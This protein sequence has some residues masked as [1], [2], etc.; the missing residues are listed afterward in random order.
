M[1]RRRGLAAL[2]LAA[3]Y[4]AGAPAHAGGNLEA[5]VANGT[6]IA[7]AAWDTRALPVTWRIN[8]QGVINNCNN[9]NPTCSGGVSPLT[10]QRAIDAMI[11]DFNAWQDVPSSRIA[12][13]FAG[14][15]A[16]TTVGLDELRL[17]TWT[18]NRTNVCPTG[19]VATT[20]SSR[21]SAD[22]TVTDGNRDLNGDGRSDLDPAIYPSGTVLKAG[23]IVDADIAWCS[24]GV[25]F[26]DVPLDTTTLTFD[27][28]AVGTH[29]MGHFHGLAH[30]SLIQPIATML[31]FVD[32]KAAYAQDVRVL[33]Q[34][35]VAS[36]SRYYPEPAFNT[37]HGVITGR[38]FLPGTTTPATGVSVTAFDLARA[39]A[40]V[41]VFSVSQFTASADPPGSFRIDGLPPG[42]Y[43]VGVEYFDS[44][45]GTMGQGED[46]WWD[47]NRYNLTVVN[48]NVTGVG[49][50]LD[51]RPEFYSNPETGTD[52]LA[53]HVPV[54][55]AAGAATDIGPIFIN[56][57]PPP[58]PSSATPLNL[59]NGS[60]AQVA[61]PAGF[62]F[63]FFGQSWTSVF[64]N[65][66]GNLTFG[67]S[68]VGANT[69]NFLGP[70]VTTGGAVPPRIAAPLTNLDPSIDNRGQSGAEIDVFARFV[71]DAL[72]DRMEIIYL[73][74]PVI[75]T[76]K[77]CTV[78]V[79]LFRTGRIE[80][81]YGF[82]SAWW[83]IVG[84]SPGGT[85]GAPRAE[86]DI[87]RQLPFSGTAGQ[88]V[89][90]HFEFNQPVEVGGTRALGD[91]FDLN[92]SL[93]VFTPN[94]AGGYDLTSPTFAVAPPREVQN[95]QFTGN[96]SL[97][98]DPRAEAAT[99]NLYRGNLGSFIDTDAD[100]AAQDYGTCLLNGMTAVT[101]TDAAVPAERSGFFYI[102][103]GR[104]AG[105][106]SPFG[107][108]GNG[109][110]RPNTTPCP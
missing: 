8:D 18:D 73:A 93:L 49:T 33:S 70:D 30:S 110:P 39:E 59:N 25:D 94:A 9:G 103:T 53:P 55:V 29:E 65:D 51:P 48:G 38:L 57:N 41:Q 1:R 86:I 46:D 27:V 31:P 68:S 83:G 62:G 40:I 42:V 24:A 72:G 47:N 60:A 20:P 37:D 85:G 34:D 12:F 88:A 76:K 2:L 98:W 10:L 16:Q 64:V 109:A 50:N 71:S 21:L 80:V 77:S 5:V 87:S 105:G 74:V 82:F 19:V 3:A 90:E 78:T 96:A 11:A 75:T 7:D 91:A 101:A 23:T 69:R 89:F 92:G 106:E 17:L 15:S 67:A 84:V 4:G 52:D 107:N 99:Y 56:I 6:R 35:D 104:N 43:H 13:S 14:T 32:N 22:L 102:V 100:G 108:A 66:N 79:R 26:V 28:G 54:N 45:T 58:A 95:L 97:Q 61:F 36:S 44:V 63:P 81:Q